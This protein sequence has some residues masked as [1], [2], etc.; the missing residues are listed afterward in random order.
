MT[1]DEL[2][3]MIAK[4][5]KQIYKRF[6]AVDERF[7]AVDARFNAVDER[8]DAIDARFDRVEQR[9][10]RVE[11]LAEDT[12]G[13]LISIDDRLAG[14]EFLLNEANPRTLKKRVEKLETH[15]F[16]TVKPA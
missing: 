14:T 5:F 15:A 12:A 1:I 9:L 2:G 6:D 13:R 16:G 4:E 7:D 11:E 3:A 8:F 10:E